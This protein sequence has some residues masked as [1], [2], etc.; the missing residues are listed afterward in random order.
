MFRNPVCFVFLLL[1]TAAVHGQKM[2]I[3]PVIRNGALTPESSLLKYKFN[4]PRWQSVQYHHNFYVLVQLNTIADSGVKLEF[5]QRGVDLVQ[6]ISG[7]SYLASVD[8]SFQMKHPGEAGIRNL[9]A[10][11]ASLKIAGGL[12][13]NAYQANGPKDLI[14][15]TCFPFDPVTIAQELTHAG[16]QIV[17][18]KIK[19]ANTWFIH[20]SQAAM[21][22]ISRIPF[23]ISLTALHLEDFPLNYNNHAIHGVQSLSATAGRNLYGKNLVLGVGDNADPST[24]IDLAGK[25]IMRTDEPVADH[26][27]HTAGILAGGGIFNPLYAGMAPRARLVVNDFSNILVN[28]PTY[29]AD[30]NMILSSNSYYNGTAG[31]A[32]E[33]EYNVLSNYVDAQLITYPKLLHVFAAG[34]DGSFTCAPF[35]GHFATIKSG[36]QTAKNVL[37]VG[38]MNNVTYTIGYGSSHGPVA[39]GRIKPEIVAGGVNIVSTVSNNGYAGLT[40]TSMACPTAAGIVALLVERYRQLNS[41]AYPDGALIK[42]LVT[43]SADD[44]GNPGP[45][46]TYGF[47]MVNGRTSVDAM[48]QNHYFTG[49]SSNNGANLFTIP[50]VTAGG[51]QLKIMLYWPDVPAIPL[52]A[53]ALVNDLDLTVTEPGGTVHHPMILDPSAGGVNNNAV[54]GADHL[55]NI[56]QVL[57]NN[58]GAGNYAIQVLGTSVPAGPQPFDIAYEWIPMSVKMEYP[59][60]SETW[61]PGT[62]ETLRWSAYGGDPNTFTLEYSTDGGSSWNL[63]NNSIA[64]TARSYS[65]TVPNLFTKNALMRVTRNVVAFTD[66]STYSFSIL[67]QPTLASSNLCAGYVQLNW[68][69]IAG[70]SSYDVMKLSGDTMQVIAQTADSAYLV[71]PLN[72]DSSY[73]FSV[74]AV[75]A[76]TPGRRAVAVNS[77]PNGGACTAGILNNDLL[78][79]SLLSPVSGRQFTSSQ[80]GIQ[81]IRVN[82]KNP[83]NLATSAPISFSYQ[84]NGFLPVTEIFSGVIA[85]Q[86]AMV[87]TFSPAN[88]YDFSAA[89]SYDIKCWIHY[90]SDTIPRNDTIETQLKNLRNDP[91]L[92]NPSFTEGFESAADRSYQGRIV[93]LDSLDRSDFSNSN[94]AGR[95]NSFFNTGFA[96]TGKRSM[97]LDVNNDGIY[98]ADSLTS[99]F[100]LSNYSAGDQLWLD[101]YF[102]KQSTVPGLGGNEI[103]IRGNDQAA[104]IPVKNL[105]DPLDPTGIYIKLNLD[106]TGLLAAASPTQTISSSFQLRCGAEGKTPA[107]STNPQAL[108]GGGISFDDFMFTHSLHDAGMQTLI[109]PGLKN[110]C[111]LTNAEK[112]TVQIKNFG[113]DTLMNIP[114]SYAI[115]LDTVTEIIPL[116]APKDSLQYTFNKTADLSVYQTYHIKTWVSNPTD[117]Y[118]NNDSSSDYT[119]QTTPLIN[120]YPYLEGFE[121]NNGYWYTGG[122]NDSWQWGKPAK[123]VIHKA[124]NGSNAWVTNLTGNYNDNEYSFL[125][126]PCF[127]LTTLSHPVLSF[128]HI[129]QTE[130]DCNC[131]FHWVEYTLDDSAWKILGNTTTGVNWYDDVL[132]KAWQK[133]DSRWHVSSYDIPVVANKIRFRIVMYSDPGTN[134]EGVGIDDIHV[135]DK[136]PVFTDSLQTSLSFP[137]NG[138]NWIDFE[139]NGKKILSLNAN[140]QDLGIVKATLYRDTA[141]I[142]DTAGQ[143]YGGRNWVIQTGAN[144]SGDVGVRFY[145]TDSEANQLLNVSSCGSCTT[146]EDAYSAGITQYSSPTI[147]EEDSTLRN[148]RSGNYLFH[149]PQQEVQIIPYDNGYYAETIVTGFSEFWINGGG[150]NHDHPLAAWL[151]DFTV[152]KQGTTGLL[153]WTSWRETGSLRYVVEKSVDSVVF[154][155]IGN[156]AAFSPSD[157]IH[158]YQFTDTALWAGKNYYRLVLYNQ[159]GDSL[160]SPVRAL[161]EPVAAFQT[162]V[163]P[164]PT[165]GNIQ[166]NTASLCRQIQLFDVTGRKLMDKS[167]Q[168]TQQQLSLSAFSAGVYLLKVYTDQG[169]KLIKVEKR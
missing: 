92:L 151:K 167:C 147:S 67:G 31:C 47:G 99:T 164:N 132:A 42:T 3:L 28:S 118:R 78:V 80:L 144:V 129:F 8:E 113:T 91:L 123:T 79:D 106:V 82:V 156:M 149:K 148:N 40:G 157:S 138:T 169:E 84:I 116:L 89:G 23:V 52:S 65:W 150:K 124:A 71:T 96:R 49:I 139:L 128:S 32:G 35:P 166:V 72:K 46:F 6:Y 33:G 126:S 64:N 94:S 145:F 120:Q 61:V 74:R 10:I 60:G 115:N 125:Y 26:G 119:I 140:G 68:N 2:G 101:L 56:E 30:Y 121:N 27:T 17:E 54:E 162:G 97:L 127:D 50:A 59:F 25:L 37:T 136:A 41:G 131:D 85:A 146:M 95:L 55:N 134:Y 87:Y 76:G 51:Y 58:P 5:K 133:S 69:R 48:E 108:A 135:F 45:D 53:T 29:V 159:N 153:N 105:S 24:H 36:F 143:Y 83:G 39:D 130:D 110:I 20:S 88:N 93:G 86:S 114:V 117:N 152:T 154:M 155:P 22:K 161:Y 107:A 75:N 100:N 163:F 14:A 70:A 98:A 44:L 43:N 158:A 122:Q 15:V 77:L 38:S 34:N 165:T 142:R 73:W 13:N 16:A 112:I 12:K 19:P 18:T 103:W 57:I 102:K 81:G 104:W 1:F 63:I 11:P 21:E 168:G 4:H 7:T 109:Q 141:A 90:A 160:I 62:T 111:A 9:F 66:Q 137:V